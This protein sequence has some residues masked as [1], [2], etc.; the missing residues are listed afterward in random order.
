MESERLRTGGFYVIGTAARARE[1]KS[2]ATMGHD[3][4]S[5]APGT[6]PAPRAVR[7]LE[8]LLLVLLW[9]GAY[10]GA[11]VVTGI[12]LGGAAIRRHV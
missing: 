10:K 3:P 6:C 2:H 4:D 9:N 12:A 8:L 7:L 11:R 1:L 5:N